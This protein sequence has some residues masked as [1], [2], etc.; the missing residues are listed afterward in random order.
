MCLILFIIG[1]SL[2]KAAMANKLSINDAEISR[3]HL[4][5]ATCQSWCSAAWSRDFH[6]RASPELN[7]DPLRLQAN[8]LQ[9]NGGKSEW[10]QC[11]TIQ[12]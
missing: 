9:K 4:A 8:V 5:I 12:A 2:A 11:W 6:V 1:R 7:E 3:K 10:L